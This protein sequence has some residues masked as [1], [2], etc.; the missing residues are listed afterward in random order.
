MSNSI[1]LSVIIPAYNEAEKLPQTLP[2]TSAYLS[3]QSY[4]YEII[5][6]NDGSRDRTADVVRELIPQVK[7]LKLIDNQENHGK[8]YVVRQGM[9]QAMG[10]YRLFTDADNSTT[11]D[12]LERMW[13]VFKEGYDVVIGSRDVKGAKMEPAQ[14]L[15]RRLLGEIFNLI[16]QAVV[17]LW[18]IWDTQCGFKTFTKKLVEEIFPKCKIN[19][20]AFDPEILIL[21]KKAGYKIKEVP[22]FWKNDARS[23]VKFTWM[24][25]MLF[26]VLQIR[27][28]L[29]TGKYA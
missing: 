18:G 10:E 15:F 17:G 26:E 12:H 20:F 13:P 25:K 21:A 16:V 5:V 27:W 9:L 14:P 19:R 29:M 11:I 28:N 2:E 6:V 7:N 1:H 22:I 23:T 24:L 4:S 8:G 3:R